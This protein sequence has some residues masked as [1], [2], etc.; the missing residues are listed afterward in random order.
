LSEDGLYSSIWS[1]ISVD[2]D[3]S[4]LLKFMRFEY[5][6]HQCICHFLSMVPGHIDCRLWESLSLRLILRLR[7][8]FGESSCPF[9]ANAPAD[10]IISYLS[11]KHGGNVHNKGIITILTKTHQ[12]GGSKVREIAE[13]TE[14]S[15]KFHYWSSSMCHINGFAGI[16]V[17]SAFDRRIICFEVN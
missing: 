3:A 13:V 6:S 17:N 16:F 9:P 7:L 11:G 2:P 12:M 14:S 15:N 5:L 4:G 1:R 10:G 8:S